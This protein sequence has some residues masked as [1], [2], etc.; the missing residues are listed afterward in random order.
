MSTQYE[1]YLLSGDSLV[2]SVG[3]SLLHIS[4]ILF[5]NQEI[6]VT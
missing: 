2:V 6:A 4:S 3:E 1:G 5:E